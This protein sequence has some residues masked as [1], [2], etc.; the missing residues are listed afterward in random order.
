MA[1]MIN[2]LQDNDEL[3]ARQ[4]RLKLD[5]QFSHLSVSLATFKAH[6]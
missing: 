5:E 4:I 6:S 3:T 2:K 1:G